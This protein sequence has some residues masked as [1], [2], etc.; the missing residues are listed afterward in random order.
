MRNVGFIAAAVALYGIANGL[1]LNATPQA[2]LA[3]KLTSEQLGLIGAGVPIGYTLS[4]LIAGRIFVRVPAK[5]VLLGGVCL[6]I[7]SLLAMAQAR[8]SA[9]CVAAQIGCGAAGGAFWPFASSWMLD[10]HSPQASRTRILRWYNVAWTGGTALGMFASG[11]VCERGYIFESLQ[12]AAGV[13]ALALMAALIAKA[14]PPHNALNGA[15]ENT[16][17]RPHVGAALLAAAV[18]AN[19]VALGTRSVLWNNYAEL[20]KHF[21]FGAERMGLITAMSLVSQL[22]AFMAGGYYEAWLGLRRV[23]VLMAAILV[24][25]NLAFA[26]SHSLPLLLIVTFAL[27]VVMALAFQTAIMAA[28]GCFASPRAAT[29][30]HEATVGAGGMMPLLAGLGVAFLKE[31]GADSLLALRAPFLAL[32]GLIL[33]FLALQ[34]V[35]IAPRRQL[36]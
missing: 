10:F 5:H 8:T 6:A 4:C 7:V 28:I 24:G 20:N 17:Q 22:L 23:Y 31:R 26:Y 21:Q 30:F 19:I 3:L 36:P 18:S 14:T 35:L 12:A 15:G 2:C 34:M 11:I 32:A 25:A 29:T 33:V 1:L 16:P 27:G 9:V 13:S